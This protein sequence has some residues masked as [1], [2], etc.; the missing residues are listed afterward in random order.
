L[1]SHLEEGYSKLP[2]EYLGPRKAMQQDTERAPTFYSSPYNA[3]GDKMKQEK[4]G[5]NM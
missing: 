5:Y 1:A 4:N 3:N 2:R